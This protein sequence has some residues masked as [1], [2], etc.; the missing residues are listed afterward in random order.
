[1]VKLSSIKYHKW[2]KMD[3]ERRRDYDSWIETDPEL[4]VSQ[5]LRSNQPIHGGDF[6]SEKNCYQQAIGLIQVII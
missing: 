6:W 5:T 4:S 2:D 1:M 3:R